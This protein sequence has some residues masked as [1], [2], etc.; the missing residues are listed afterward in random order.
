[1]ILEEPQPQPQLHQISEESAPDSSDD[2]MPELVHSSKPLKPTQPTQ[3]T[4]S[5]KLI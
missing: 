3:P 2:D 1:M 5:Q 4:R